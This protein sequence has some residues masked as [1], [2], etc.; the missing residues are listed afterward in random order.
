MPIDISE[1]LAFQL[2]LAATPAGAD[3][4]GK[5]PGIASGSGCSNE[6]KRCCQ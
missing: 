3:K 6:R 2:H 1:A 4:P 5:L